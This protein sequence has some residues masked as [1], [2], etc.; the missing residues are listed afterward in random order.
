[1]LTRISRLHPLWWLHPHFAVLFIGIPFLI[2]A[3]LTP[4]STYL[5]LYRTNKY[6]DFNFI[7]MGLIVYLGFFAGSFFTVNTGVKNQERDIILYCRWFVWPLFIITVF[8]HVV[9]YANTALA[10]GGLEP[11]ISQLS[12]AL[13][14]PEVGTA[15][16]MRDVFSK[17][18]P[19]ITT[20][21]LCGIL[22][23]TVEALL[24]VRRNSHRPLALMRFAIVVSLVLVRA[25]LLTERLAIIEIA[26]PATIIL[27][28]KL[29]LSTA[30]RRH[31]VR[32][33]PLFIVLGALGAFASTE[34]VRSWAYYR[35]FYPGNYLEFVFHRFVGYYTT[36]VNNAAVY[37]YY[38]PLQPFRHTLNDLFRFP[39]LGE[40]VDKIHAAIFGDTYIEIPYLLNTY[41]NYEFNVTPMFGLLLNEWTVFFAPVV[42]FLIGLLSSS[43]YSSFSR[44]R[45]IGALLY[46]S[47]FIGLL[48]ISRIYYWAHQRYFPVLVFLL[49]S[50]LLYK[51]VK[52]PVPNKTRKGSSQNMKEALGRQTS[53]LR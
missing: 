45:L 24:W 31:A 37:Y 47:W 25:V 28:S 38:Q 6:V 10:A 40:T 50:L 2:L 48:E 34:Y 12:R 43:L 35:T 8:G 11:T 9:W 30:F 4:E 5:T 27:L 32:F 44:G 1:M 23:A 53:T 14:Q 13:L 41:A 16:Y 19:G 46:P 20:L 3:Y 15:T 18:V 21:A 33:A 36:S 22:Y 26:V 42:A 51:F 17:T 29:Q 7:I 52:V 39:V 49:V